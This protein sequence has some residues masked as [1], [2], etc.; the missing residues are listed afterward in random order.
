MKRTTMS[1]VSD[2]AQEI[3]SQL[4]ECWLPRLYRDK[5]LTTR[6]RSYQ[7]ETL[8]RTGR[9]EIQHTLLGIELKVGRRRYSCPDLGT[10]RYLSVFARAGCQKLALP[11]DITQLSCLADQLESS[12][13][14]LLLLV[15]HS[16]PEV[17]RP[18]LRGL[19]IAR[20]RAEIV[21]AG[22]GS[23]MPRFKQSTR[24]RPTT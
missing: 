11:Y 19:L 6:T 18:R 1:S 10:A 8:P 2:R 14:R 3:I 7:F 13:Q 16:L 17:N 23:I 24:Q 12:W 9:V 5:I 22:A 20:L 4:G 15:D 21:A